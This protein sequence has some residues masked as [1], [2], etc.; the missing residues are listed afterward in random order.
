MRI[1]QSTPPT[2]GAT[3]YMTHR[4]QPVCVSIHAPHAGGDHDFP[5]EGT[6]LCSVSIHAPHAGG[7]QSPSGH[8]SG[9]IPVSIHAP[10]AG[11]DFRGGGSAFRSVSIHAPHAGGDGRT[12]CSTRQERAP[13]SIH[14]PHAGGD[15]WRAVQGSLRLGPQRF[16]PRPPRGGR[17]CHEVGANPRQSATDRFNPRPPRGGRR[18]RVNTLRIR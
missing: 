10:H 14:A 4:A 9:T 6:E 11:G 13:V 8:S 1:W 16:N 17:P 5:P 18:P 12:R 15:L 3:T 2:R 7:D